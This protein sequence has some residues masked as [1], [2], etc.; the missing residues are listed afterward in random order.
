MVSDGRIEKRVTVK[1][2][3]H[4]VPMEN[5]FTAET[6]T[7]VNVSHRGARVLTGRR[8]KPGEQLGVT[9]LS[10]EFR[11][12]GK[13][14]YCHPVAEGQFCVGLEFGVNGHSWKDA[15]WVGAT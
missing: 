12:H 2:P 10:G 4:I 5:A 6:T 13:V 1:V 11:R 9:S 8:W 3:V 14:I 7:M 15:P